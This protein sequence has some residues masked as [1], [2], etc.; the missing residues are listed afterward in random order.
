[1]A[2]HDATKL[3]KLVRG[4]VEHSYRQLAKLADDFT[5]IQPAASE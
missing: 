5:R 4:H 3:W 1:M 2:A